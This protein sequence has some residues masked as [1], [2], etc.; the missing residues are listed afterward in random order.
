MQEAGIELCCM[1]MPG[2]PLDVKADLQDIAAQDTVKT[3]TYIRDLVPRRFGPNRSPSYLEYSATL[4]ERRIRQLRPQAVIV[5][6]NYVAALPALIA[7]RRCGI[8]LA[9]EVR[10]FWEITDVSREPDLAETFAH[11]LKIRV[12]SELAAR[13]VQ[14]F[15]LS[16]PIAEELVRRGVGPAR[17]ALLA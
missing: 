5:A 11:Q 6:S 15:T 7:A 4:I 16:E 10:G 3:V 1:T 14:I 2:F 12:E 9:Y 8:P 13:M 17:I